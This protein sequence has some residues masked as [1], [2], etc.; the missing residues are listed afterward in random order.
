MKVISNSDIRDLHPMI[1]VCETDTYYSRFANKLAKELEKVCK[2][3]EYDKLNDRKGAFREMVLRLTLYF[4]D[5]VSELGLWTVYAKRLQMGPGITEERKEA[6]FY[7]P[8]VEAAYFLIAMGETFS[9]SANEPDDRSVSLFEEMGACAC[10]FMKERF[11]D[12][13]FNDE[14]LE[15]VIAQFP[16]KSFEAISKMFIWISFHSYMSAGDTNVM[17]GL[18]SNMLRKVGLSSWDADDTALSCVALTYSTTLFDAT[19]P[20]IYARLLEETN[21]GMLTKERTAA[22]AKRLRD[23]KAVP[24]QMLKIEEIAGNSI[25][26]ADK[27]GNIMQARE[28]EPT[29]LELTQDDGDKAACASLILFDGEWKLN[30]MP[31]FMKKYSKELQE[32]CNS[33]LLDK[34]NTQCPNELLAENRY[35]EDDDYDEDNDEDFNVGNLEETMRNMKESFEREKK[36]YPPLPYTYNDTAEYP[37]HISL[38]KPLEKYFLRKKYIAQPP[39][40]L[41][42]YFRSLPPEELRIQLEDVVLHS[43]YC[44]RNMKRSKIKVE[45]LHAAALWLGEVGDAHSLEVLLQSLR[46]SDEYLTYFFGDFSEKAYT[47]ALCRLAKGNERVLADFTML[48]EGVESYSRSYAFSALTQSYL[49]DFISRE[50]YLGHARRVL[51]F[52]LDHWEEHRYTDATL[53]SFIICELLDCQC[54]ELLPLLRE[55]GK[56]DA[57]NT[58]VC[59]KMEEVEREITSKRYPLSYYKK[60]LD[61]QECIGEWGQ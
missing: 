15:A 32:E 22:A 9:G 34:D 8:T 44:F 6:F 3:K 1:M 46:Q 25:T 59:G 52:F 37:E 18:M 5:I 55:L 36:L 20:E 51:T 47:P 39:A 38:D 60:S 28:V 29:I 43:I 54:K 23:I 26:F 33:Y 11:D 48:S 35:D 10:S 13:P 56:K 24:F 19:A 31:L 40:D 27:D 4:E 17:A 30:G 16:T 61:L 12:A 49:H 14:L 58:F 45:N 2:E 21:S 50:E 7:E 53:V 42:A 57:F 41:E